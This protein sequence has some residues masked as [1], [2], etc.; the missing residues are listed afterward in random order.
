VA[1]SGE[2][3][4]VVICMQDDGSEIRHIFSTRERA[5][6]FMLEDD[7]RGHIYY[8]YVLDDPERH[9]GRHVTH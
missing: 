1:V 4:H 6:A 7:D 8:D 9:E 3:V 2:L 5:E